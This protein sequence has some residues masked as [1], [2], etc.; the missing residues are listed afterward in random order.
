MTLAEK[1]E[2]ALF[3]LGLA[4]WNVFSWLA[5]VRPGPMARLWPGT[6]P[7]VIRLMAAVFLAAGLAFCGFAVAQLAAGTFKWKGSTRTYGFSDLVR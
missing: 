5:V 7:R 3:L 4:V 2:F 6:S 1:L